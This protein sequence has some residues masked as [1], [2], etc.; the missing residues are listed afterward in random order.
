MRNDGEPKQNA[1]FINSHRELTPMTRQEFKRC[2]IT[3]RS[4]AGVLVLIPFA[5][6]ALGWFWRGRFLTPDGRLNPL[7]IA[8][9]VCL[10]FSLLGS[11]SVV[12]RVY[13]RYLVSCP[14]CRKTLLGTAG[15][16]VLS[17]GRCGNCGH[18]ILTKAV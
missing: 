10:L 1:W 9:L 13:R 8:L 3:G 4:L 12:G 2:Q 6:L 14:K 16:I 18:V 7:G 11:L 17:T 15:M 5:M